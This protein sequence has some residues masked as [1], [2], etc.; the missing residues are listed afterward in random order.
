MDI[1]YLT[2]ILSN[3]CLCCS[4]DRQ[5]QDSTASI[6]QDEVFL[7]VSQLSAVFQPPAKHQ[8]WM[9]LTHNDKQKSCSNYCGYI[10]SVLLY[11]I[12]G[13]GAVRVEQ[14]NC[15]SSPSIR[16]ALSSRHT[17]LGGAGGRKKYI[18]V[19]L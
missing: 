2:L 8:R 4:D 13:K 7:L 6:I 14:V 15:M 1:L 19:H 3:I 12:C 11:L 18:K 10:S 16:Q 9:C 5:T 17:N